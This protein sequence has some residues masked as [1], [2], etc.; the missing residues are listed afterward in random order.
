[1]K[2]AIPLVV[3]ILGVASTVYPQTAPLYGGNSDVT[4]NNETNHDQTNQISGMPPENQDS[5]QHERS[6]S[7]GDGKTWEHPTTESSDSR[8]SNSGGFNDRLDPE[9]ELRRE[10]SDVMNLKIENEKQ[11]VTNGMVEKRV[12]PE[13]TSQAQLLD[14]EGRYLLKEQE[15]LEE[16]ARQLHEKEKKLDERQSRLDEEELKE[17]SRKIHEKEK[18]WNDNENNTDQQKPLS[19]P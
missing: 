8:D 17:F 14:T 7:Q 12:E 13:L 11:T 2:T 5:D 19:K 6:L 18:T 16:F 1:M 3:L 15:D 9:M 10:R 4:Q